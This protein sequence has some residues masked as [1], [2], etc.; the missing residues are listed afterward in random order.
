MIFWYNIQILISLNVDS[1][2]S[3]MKNPKLISICCNYSSCC[4]AY[5][6]L[7][8]LNDSFI[9]FQ[10]GFLDQHSNFIFVQYL[11]IHCIFLKGLCRNTRSHF[12]ICFTSHSIKNA[13]ANPMPR[14]LIQVSFIFILAFRIDTVSKQIVV[15]IIF[16]YFPF[17][18]DYVTNYFFV[19][20][21]ISPRK[22]L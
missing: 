12:S 5:A 13:N 1:A 21:H 4:P 11:Q 10:K 6:I 7:S 16:S 15:F 3:T 19:F 14:W 9:C 20:F 17:I 18:T 8:F 2:I 22:F